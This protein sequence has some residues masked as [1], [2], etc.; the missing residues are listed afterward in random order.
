[1]ELHLQQIAINVQQVHNHSEVMQQHAL[2]A[3]AQQDRE[4]PKLEL[5]LTLMDAIHV[6]QEH[7]QQ[8]AQQPHAL[9]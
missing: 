1:L 5:Q 9:I 4:P 3:I 7:S 6:Q 8:E 2:I